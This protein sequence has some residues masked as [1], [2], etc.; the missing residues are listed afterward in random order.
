[1]PSVKL[2]PN[3]DYALKSDEWQ[4]IPFN[5]EILKPEGMEAVYADDR[6]VTV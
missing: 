2:S 3:G 1:M 4:Q 6:P 5:V